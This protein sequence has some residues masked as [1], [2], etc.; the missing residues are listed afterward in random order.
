MSLFVLFFL[1]IGFFNNT[2]ACSGR[3][4]PVRPRA[5]SYRWITLPRDQP[6]L[7]LIVH[8]AIERN[9]KAIISFLQ[10][11]L[12]AAERE[13]ARVALPRTIVLNTSAAAQPTSGAL[14]SR[15]AQAGG[16]KALAPAQLGGSG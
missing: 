3:N 11:R 14:V 10:Q 8:D 9:K 13:G 6:N 4:S 2:S 12:D 7:I 15:A 5:H 1:M 16:G